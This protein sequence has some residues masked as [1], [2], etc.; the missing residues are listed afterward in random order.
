MKQFISLILSIAV[1]SLISCSDEDNNTNPK[2]SNVIEGLTQFANIENSAYTFE[3]FTFEELKSGYNDIYLRIKDSDGNYLKGLSPEIYFEMDMGMHKHSTPFVGFENL[4]EYNNYY[5]AYAVFI[6]P[7]TMN[8]KWY[9]DFK[10]EIDESNI[11]FNH[12][13]H[14]VAGSM[15]K[16]FKI[17]EDVYWF[18]IKEPSKP[19]VGINNLEVLIHKRESM[20]S[21]PPV[22]GFEIEFEPSMPSMGHGSPNNENPSSKGAGLYRGKVNYTMT[23]DWLLEFKVKS[24]GVIVAELDFDISL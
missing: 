21:F 16:N 1:L 2:D 15:I 24:D 11:E 19:K 12:D 14:V 22:S 10:C 7:T 3:F 9:F 4:E 18:T 20:M 8:G 6:M 13:F 23:G 5:K 17:G